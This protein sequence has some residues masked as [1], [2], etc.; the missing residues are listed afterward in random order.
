MGVLLNNVIDFVY[1]KIVNLDLH[2][3]R[4]VRPIAYEKLTCVKAGCTT[5]YFFFSV[6][7]VGKQ[8]S[9]I[10]QQV[11]LLGGAGSFTTLARRHYAVN[12]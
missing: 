5:D 11:A 2:C 8:I 3:T 9:L 4:R 12:S 1:N 10:K 7:L 6:V